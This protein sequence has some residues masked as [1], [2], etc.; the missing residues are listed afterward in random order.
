M[1]YVDEKDRKEVVKDLRKIY[2]SLTEEQARNNLVAFEDK[3]GKKYNYV[4]K[5]WN[6]NWAEL[7]AFLDFP[8]GMRKMIYTT[9]P[10]E[11][12]HRVIRKLIKSKSAWVS[13]RALTKQIYLWL[14][15]NK[16]SWIGQPYQ[17]L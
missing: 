8:E 16:K 9:N 7:M 12:L 2:T 14:M 5:Q 11:A 4:V 13:E 1:R 17:I 15:R 6:E 10:V 3:W